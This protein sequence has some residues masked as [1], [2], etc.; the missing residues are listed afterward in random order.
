MFKTMLVLALH[1]TT[2]IDETLI[3]LAGKNAEPDLKT[4]V[5]KAAVAVVHMHYAN[6]YGAIK[7]QP[8]AESNQLQ[9]A[10]YKATKV[11]AH[12]LNYSLHKFKDVLIEKNLFEEFEM[13][14]KMSELI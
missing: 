12:N 1:T 11:I 13:L 5:I 7:G 2:L 4:K 6:R 9:Q 8:T 10:G 3:K 14:T